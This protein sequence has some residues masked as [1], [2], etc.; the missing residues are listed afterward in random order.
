MDWVPSPLQSKNSDTFLYDLARTQFA[1]I[2]EILQNSR[3]VRIHILLTKLAIQ[4][5]S[6]PDK[7][8]CME[9]NRQN[10]ICMYHCSINYS[11]R[12]V[13]LAT[14]TS[15]FFVLSSAIQNRRQFGNNPEVMKSIYVNLS[16]HWPQMFD[17][18][19]K[20]KVFLICQRLFTSQ[21]ICS[22]MPLV[23]A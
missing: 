22:C 23:L 1:F 10:P 11:V 13:S 12:T 19:T 15:P 14:L 3:F 5:V 20:N 8:A 21:C 16:A 2:P 6:F 17:I 9:E 18:S 4:D 7:T